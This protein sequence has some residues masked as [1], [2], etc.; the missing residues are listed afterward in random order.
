[1]KEYKNVETNE[2]TRKKKVGTKKEMTKMEENKCAK[3]GRMVK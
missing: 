2:N 1:M 3:N